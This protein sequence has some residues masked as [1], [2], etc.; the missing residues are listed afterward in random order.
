MAEKTYA[1]RAYSKIRDAL[2]FFIV[3]SN[4][5]K[6]INTN[7]E[8][9]KNLY[10]YMACSLF[11]SEYSNARIIL[12]ANTLPGGNALSTKPTIYSDAKAKISDS[13]IIIYFL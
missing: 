11:R 9:Y 3:L 8:E 4:K 10:I 7:I 2:L 1:N 13:K 12:L 5:N 6:G